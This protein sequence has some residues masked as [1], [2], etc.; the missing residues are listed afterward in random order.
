MRRK[1]PSSLA[2]SSPTVTITTPHAATRPSLQDQT[3]VPKQDQILN[4]CASLQAKVSYCSY[5]PGDGCIYHVYTTSHQTATLTTSATLDQI[6][7]REVSPTPRRSQH[8][9]LS[10][11]I[12]SSFIQLLNSPWFPSAF[13]GKS[14][15]HFLS[16]LDKPNSYLLNQPHIRRDLSGSACVQIASQTT[17]SPGPNT[18]T[19]ALD[20]LGII[21]LCFGQVLQEQPCRKRWPAG[22]SE[23]ER[24][25]FDT[26]AARDWQ[27]E[28]N[29]EAGTDF[30]EVIA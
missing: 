5:L 2:V 21:V 15:I 6:L 14:D 4:L 10:L 27:C 23:Q 13:I 24:A 30:A 17:P 12:T 7:R 11:A 26:M 18:F 8:Y 28:V 9:K 19:D 3:H 1:Q 29:G 20:H 25:I 16:E 22:S